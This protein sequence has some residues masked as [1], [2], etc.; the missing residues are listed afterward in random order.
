MAQSYNEI[1]QDFAKTINAFKL[2]NSEENDELLMQN[3]K[4]VFQDCENMLTEIVNNIQI[5]LDENAI[6]RLAKAYPNSPY[7]YHFHQ[8]ISD[9]ADKQGYYL[10]RLLPRGWFKITLILPKQL[11]FRLVFSIHHQ[12]LSTSMVTILPF[13]EFMEKRKYQ[14][15][16]NIHSKDKEHEM[17]SDYVISDLPIA[18]DPYTF[19]LED[20]TLSFEFDNIKNYLESVIKLTFLKITEVIQ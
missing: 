1:M 7:Y 14:N 9:L 16:K 3:R 2:S 6:V 4:R 19:F 12:G 11:K 18:A 13:L 17:D 8:Q 10:N 15:K 20:D 5:A